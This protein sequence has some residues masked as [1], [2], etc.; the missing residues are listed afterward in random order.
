MG[1]KARKEVMGAANSTAYKLL[2]DPFPV[3]ADL[4]QQLDR[5]SLIAMRIL[6][7]PDIYDFKN[8]KKPYVCNTYAVFLK[9]NI[10]K[11]LLP[12]VSGVKVG[13]KE[14]LLD[15]V[16]Q[17]PSKSFESMEVRKQVCSDIAQTLVRVVTTVVACLASIQV[18]TLS[19]ESYVAGVVGEGAAPAPQRGGRQ[20]RRQRGGSTATVESWLQRN[21]VIGNGGEGESANIFPVIYSSEATRHMRDIPLLASLNPVSNDQQTEITFTMKRPL[22]GVSASVKALVS[23]PLT[24]TVGG[25]TYEALP[26]ILSSSIR[27][28]AY[29]GAIV[30]TTSIRDPVFISMAQTGPSSTKGY[31]IT[32]LLENLILKGLGLQVQ[33]GDETS[34]VLNSALT[35]VNA[36]IKNPAATLSAF[37]TQLSARIATVFNIPGAGGAG[38]V[39]P[40]YYGA[41]GVQAYQGAPGPYGIPQ[42]PAYGFQQP[43]RIGAPTIGHIASAPLRGIPQETVSYDIP[44]ASSTKIL[45]HF[46]DYTKS[47]A[48]ENS[49]AAIRAKMLQNYVDQNRQV[50]VGVCRD[51]YW[52]ATNA[53]A[54]YPWATLQILCVEDLKNIGEPGKVTFDDKVWGKFLS[55]LANIY[56]GKAGHPKMTYDAPNTLDKVRFSMS[57]E[58]SVPVIC[59]GTKTP[60]VRF[61]EVQAGVQ[62]LQQ[63]YAAQVRSVWGILNRIIILV[64]DPDTKEEVVRLHPQ[65]VSGGRASRDYVADIAKEARELIADF[66]VA[67][68][69]SYVGTVD[70][71]QMA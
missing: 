36:Y 33:P 40:P 19:R 42:P 44:P 71:L 65:I 53:D 50:A 27:I 38:S 47:L 51:P 48:K 15:V 14:K 55:R 9:K 17:D 20:L 10:E 34:A 37:Q 32:E 57:T 69:E 59:R 25:Q 11:K 56:D 29:A 30:Y 41:P 16:Y 52:T 22:N 60:R 1:K 46:K 2:D 3:S 13:D 23:D 62:Q 21:Y 5:L 49:P 26:L 45:S 4:S 68:E 43:P 58:E 8:L 67:V 54:I 63:I 7:T 28:A 39:V 35:T 64:Q 61:Q 70:R 18:V 12:F 31:Y 24:L 6:N 66:Y